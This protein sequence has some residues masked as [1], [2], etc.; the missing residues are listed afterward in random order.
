MVNFQVSVLFQVSQLLESPVLSST[1]DDAD[2][3]KPEGKSAKKRS[4]SKVS[5]FCVEKSA[6][7]VTALQII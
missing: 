2:F 3:V 5:R 1:P 7:T 4:N 6:K